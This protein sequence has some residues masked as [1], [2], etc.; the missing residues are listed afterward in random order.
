MI[1]I[2]LLSTYQNTVIPIALL[3][4]K[5][6]MINHHIALLVNVVVRSFC[7]FSPKCFEKE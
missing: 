2:I 7:S 3:L 6:Y 5:S 4:N 1:S